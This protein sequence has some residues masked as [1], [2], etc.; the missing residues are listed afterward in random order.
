MSTTYNFWHGSRRWEGEPRIHGPRKGRDGNGPGLHVTTWF[1]TAAEYAKQGGSVR[2]IVITPRLALQDTALSLSDAM[3][4]VTTVITKSKQEEILER[5][6]RRANNVQLH[7]RVLLGNDTHHVHAETL[8]VM[9]VNGNLALGSKGEAL[10]EFYAGQG[11]DWAYERARG[12]DEFWGVIF[13]PKIID[14]Y[15][16]VRAADIPLDQRDFPSPE[17]QRELAIEN[18]KQP[19]ARN[20]WLP[21]DPSI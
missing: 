1:D 7:D 21:G 12:R 10:A 3:D 8:L 9:C 15:D 19:S 4:F 2:R 5:L 18:L 16:R 6:M 20:I 13:N 17:Q 14:S 11:I